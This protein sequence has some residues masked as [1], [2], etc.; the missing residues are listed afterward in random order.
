MN[1]EMSKF[2]ESKEAEIKLKDDES[3]KIHDELKA[4]IDELKKENELLR[5]NIDKAKIREAEILT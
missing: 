1:Q 3:R 2:L 4:E 5:D